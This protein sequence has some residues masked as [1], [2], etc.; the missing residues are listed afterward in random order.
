MMNMNS[1]V[2]SGIL[3]LSASLCLLACQSEL[4]ET[5]VVK[6][7]GETTKCRL[8][9]HCFETKTVNNGLGTEW[10]QSDELSVFYQSGS[11]YAHSRFGY[12]ED[13]AFLQQINTFLSTHLDRI[14]FIFGS[15][16]ISGAS[17]DH[18]TP[19]GF[20]HLLYSIHI[21][22]IILYRYL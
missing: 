22:K 18:S 5:P 2:L 11:A 15:H 8:V 3:A 4:V 20:K 6:P 9:A 13:N 21:I 10:G 19:R 7:S 17:L 16:D 1:R 12:E 14:S